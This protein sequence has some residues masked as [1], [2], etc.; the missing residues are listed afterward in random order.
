[1]TI[2]KIDGRPFDTQGLSSAIKEKRTGSL[3]YGGD[4][5]IQPIQESSELGEA[6]RELNKDEVEGNARM[7]SIDLRSR[8]RD[9][10][11]SFITAFDSLIALGVMPM[12]SIVLTR[13]KKRNAVS[14]QG[15]GRQE[16][17]E[18][19]GGKK[20]RDE[21]KGFFGMFG[22]KQDKGMPQ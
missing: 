15:L 9:F 19:V 13:C 17:V 22:K 12:S 3:F 2:I 1:M 7:T 11:I 21:K 10:E 16:I 14:L 8:L 18:I 4:K 5:G 6:T 20:E